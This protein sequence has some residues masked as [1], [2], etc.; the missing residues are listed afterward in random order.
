MSA[1]SALIQGGSLRLLMNELITVENGMND[2]IQVAKDAG[3]ID[4]TIP[5]IQVH[6]WR[7]TSINPPSVYNLISP[8][9]FQQMD[10][11]RWRDTINILVRIAVAYGEDSSE[12]YILEPLTDVFRQQIDPLLAGSVGTRPFN[13][14]A[15]WAERSDMRSVEDQFNDIP[16]ACMEFVIQARMDRMIVP[17]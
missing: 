2:A 6:R 7:P 9:P 17:T 16:Y 3:L 1:D 14:A 4:T 12:M 10:Q 13:G 8:S 15:E 5:S 11:L